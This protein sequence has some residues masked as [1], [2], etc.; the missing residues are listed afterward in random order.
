MIDV[1]S[2]SLTALL[3]LVA[4]ACAPGCKSN[5][6]APPAEGGAG[7]GAGGS[8]GKAEAGGTG[9]NGGS[10]GS[11]RSD[12][13]CAPTAGAGGA[14]DEN[15]CPTAYVL[16]HYHGD[17]CGLCDPGASRQCSSV[18]DWPA[19]EGPFTECTP[20]G[21]ACTLFGADCNGLGC[22]AGPGCSVECG[23]GGTPACQALYDAAKPNKSYLLGW[24]CTNDSQCDP[25]HYCDLRVANRMFCDNAVIFYAK[26]Y[27]ADAG[28]DGGS[29]GGLDGGTDAGD[30]ASDAADAGL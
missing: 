25:G 13:G 4:L 23:W 7:S 3:A 16:P 27:C 26:D 18:C 20:D 30:A 28:V 1:R 11:P 5:S 19:N 10:G 2:S 12:S 14:L 15:H 6:A 8:G 17:T 22:G 29:E 21:T 9:G 24:V